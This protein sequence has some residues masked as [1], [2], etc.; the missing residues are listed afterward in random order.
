MFR[1]LV[2][3]R[4]NTVPRAISYV[5]VYGTDGGYNNKWY[6]V[7]CRKDSCLVGADFVSCISI[8]CHPVG[9]DN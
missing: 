8:F 2:R 1:K 5:E 3:L 9:T 4:R 6:F 7:P